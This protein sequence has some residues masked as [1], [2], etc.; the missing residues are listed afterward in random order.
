MSNMRRIFLS[1]LRSIAALLFLITV[2]TSADAT[3]PDFVEVYHPAVHQAELS[4]LDKDYATALAYYQ[5]AFAKVPTPF[6]RDYYNATVCAV[7]E[8][9]NK[10]AFEY[11]EKMVLLGV[12]L[13][14]LE[15]QEVL[16]PLQETRQ[17]KKFK[18]KYPK[19][20]REFRQ[21]AN[22]DLRAD[23]DELYA[24]DQY[25]RQAAGGL[26]VY[27]DTLRKIERANV[28]KL[29]SWINEYGYPGE[30]L[31]GVAD[32]LEEV[33]RF[34]IVIQ[35][36][37]KYRGGYDFT[38]ILTTAVHEGKMD[39]QAAAYLMDIQAGR[40]NHKAKALIKVDCNKPDDCIDNEQY[41][42]ESLTPEER[43]QIDERR[44]KLGLEPL[45]D[46]K[47]KVMFSLEDDR[48]KMNYSWSV[49]TYKVPSKEAAE[50]LVERFVVAEL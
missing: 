17:W 6:A 7:L 28:Q 49:V 10:Q 31:I 30:A 48:F 22:L 45:A 39:P 38:D 25:F 41:F 40:N 11:L 36:Q 35:R 5:Q 32:T 4:I 50:A 23:L 34:S 47:K 27:G 8:N 44:L 26:K 24:R 20:R 9:N 19:R 33:P 3:S 18:R 29:L 21:S 14:Y 42:E 43:E 15:Q 12:S 16:E 46:Y 1:F 13:P 2:S 37:T